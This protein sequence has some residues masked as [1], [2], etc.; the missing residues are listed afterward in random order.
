MKKQLLLNGLAVLVSLVVWSFQAGFMGVIVLVI[1]SLALGALMFLFVT[2]FTTLGDKLRTDGNKWGLSMLVTSLALYS[3]A[4]VMGK[5]DV[6]ATYLT[7]FILIGLGV[8]FGSLL[9]KVRL[10][11]R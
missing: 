9:K 5:V 8:T 6:F 7:L 1:T 10:P 11:R 2:G 3:L 4:G